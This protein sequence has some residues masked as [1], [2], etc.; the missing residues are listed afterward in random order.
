MCVSIA[1]SEKS[2]AVRNFYTGPKNAYTGPKTAYSG[3][4]KEYR[5]VG[6]LAVRKTSRNTGPKRNSGPK[7]NFFKTQY[8][9]PKTVYGGPLEEWRSN[10]GMA[11]QRRNA[12]PIIIFVQGR[13][14]PVLKLQIAVRRMLIPVP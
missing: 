9:G 13:G 11:V 8:A 1:Q 14:I 7:G 6:G 3:P 10:G 12:G 5:S 2:L 4:K